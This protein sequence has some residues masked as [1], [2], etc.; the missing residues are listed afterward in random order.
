VSSEETE[1]R[2]VLARHRLADLASLRTVVA[3]YL[4]VSVDAPRPRAFL[5]S[6][7]LRRVVGAVETV[8]E[9]HPEGD[10]QSFRFSAAGSDT[11]VFRRLAREVRA[12]TGLDES[13]DGDL[14]LRIRTARF[15]DSGWELLVRTSPR[16]LSTRAW[17]T[18]QMPG[19]LNATIAACVV[20]AS[21]PAATDRFID[22]MT[23][24]GTLLAERW[25][26]G[27]ATRLLG[28]DVSPAALGQARINLAHAGVGSAATLLE[29]DVTS[30]PPDLR[31]FDKL[32]VNLPWG[33][34][35]GRH[36][37]N[38]DL[39]R[40]VLTQA[41]VIAA[42]GA[43]LCALTHEVRLFERVLVDAPWRLERSWRFFQ[44]GHHPR[45]Y[46]LV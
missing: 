25:A 36:Q 22:L 23:G 44:K 24:S 20:D 14:L 17:R 15:A 46:L 8:Q 4:V 19:A 29:V 5:G 39:Y 41:R 7:H 31:G 1:L 35:S 33:T 26:A 32:V 27:P 42:P 18:E 40:A 3:A 43:R 21:S 10:V 37:T 28:C 6:E 13:G 9:L 38:P 2:L 45:L 16:P 34:R 30:P 11:A 12:A